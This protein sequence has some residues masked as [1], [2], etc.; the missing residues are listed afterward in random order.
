MNGSPSSP[1]DPAADAPCDVLVIGGAGFIGSH[2]V[3]RLVAD[4]VAVDVVDARFGIAR[5][6]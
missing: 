1:P 3:E 6:R 4:A 2:L 5:A